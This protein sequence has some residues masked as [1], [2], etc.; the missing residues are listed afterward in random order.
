MHLPL[1]P[2]R[3]G[4]MCLELKWWVVVFFLRG[5]AVL[6]LL[7]CGLGSLLALPLLLCLDS[8]PVVR[9]LYGKPELLLFR[10]QRRGQL[11][12]VAAC[13]LASRVMNVRCL[14][15]GRVKGVEELNALSSRCFRV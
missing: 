4:N 8:L 1:L 13:I 3:R 12:P 6:L 15:W 11:L 2:R 14:A 10:W 9:V 5:G 7:L